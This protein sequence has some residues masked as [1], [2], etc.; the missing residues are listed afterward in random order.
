MEVGDIYSSK[1]YG[2]FKVLEINNMR[3]ILIE[4]TDT[5]FKKKTWKQHIVT[6]NVKDL[7][8]PSV[9]GVGCIG[10]GGY[11]L[12]TGST[13]KRTEVYRKWLKITYRCYCPTDTSYKWYGGKGV[14]VSEEWLNFQN[15]AKWYEDN[16]REGFEIDKDL[17]SKDSKLYS[18]DTCVFIPRSINSFLAKSG[19]SNPCITETPVGNFSV[20]VNDSLS[21]GLRYVGTFE[22][23]EEAIEA[24]NKHKDSIRKSLVNHH[25]SLG[26]IDERT[27]KAILEYPLWND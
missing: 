2:D 14:T 1:N 7:L 9:L 13:R 3:D 10:E 27:Y 6:G 16:Y 21:D 17:L 19:R 11:K 22:S 4:F 12:H 15:F 24:R 20:Q 5:G 18:K 23:L 8:K 26:D 25:Y